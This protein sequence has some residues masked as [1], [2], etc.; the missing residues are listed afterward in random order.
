MSRADFSHSTRAPAVQSPNISK[1]NRRALL[2]GAAAA[3]AASSASASASGEPPDA[4]D[5]LWR[6]RTALVAQS[7]TLAAQMATA[8][9]SMP[10]WAR[11]GP[12]YIDGAG[13]PCGETVPFPR[14]LDPKLPTP[15]GRRLVRPSR[16]TIEEEYRSDRRSHPAEADATRARRLAAL[17]ERLA[18][19]QREEDRAGVD[20]L[21]LA[22]EANWQ[23]AL[24]IEAEIRDL[25]VT[26]NALAA[27]LLIDISYDAKRTSTVAMPD[28][29]L[30]AALRPLRFLRPAL[31]GEVAADVAALLESPEASLSSH[32]FCAA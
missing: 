26:F 24:D 15:N 4:L 25:P 7:H 17:E 23:A 16:Q 11:P 29:A 8:V 32:R 3:V 5:A 31:T 1:L 22:V 20:N 12:A 27:L 13:R 10:E 6:Q 18:A 28:T 21:Q 14:R 30:A 9:A 2:V 19:Q